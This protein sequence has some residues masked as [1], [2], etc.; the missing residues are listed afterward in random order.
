VRPERHRTI[1]VLGAQYHGSEPDHDGSDSAGTG[2]I[3]SAAEV[4][5][6]MS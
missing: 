4:T 5:M 3:E 2:D 1:H 6:S